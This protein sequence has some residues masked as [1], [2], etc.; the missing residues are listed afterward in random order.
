M[1]VQPCGENTT[2]KFQIFTAI[3]F[4]FWF[5]LVVFSFL[6]CFVLGFLGVFFVV[7]FLF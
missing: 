3:E 4:L 2:E 7:F 5:V 6:F 1:S